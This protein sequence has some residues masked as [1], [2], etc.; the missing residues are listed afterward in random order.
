MSKAQKVPVQR[1]PQYTCYRAVGAITIDGH[2]AEP[3][4]RKAPKTPPFVHIT[5]GEAVPFNTQAM[6]LWDNE[7]FY[8]AYVIEEPDVFATEGRHH[9]PVYH[10]DH[11]VELFI[12]PDG[13]AKHYYEF[14]INP[15]NTINEVLWDRTQ[16][17]RGKGIFGWDLVGLKHAVQ[18]QGTLNCPQIKDEGWTVELALPWKSMRAFGPGSS[19]PPRPGDTWR[20]NFTRVE[21]TRT[22]PEVIRSTRTFDSPGEEEEFTGPRIEGEVVESTDWVWAPAPEY[23]AH[24]CESWGFVRFSDVTVGAE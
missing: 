5:S 12:D 13:K 9:T 11:D 16:V 22:I 19:L 3:A 6:M 4:W 15:I 23:S 7:Y 14:Q 8:V 24:I 17:E 18:V 10:S 20:I 21:K 1:P 2:L